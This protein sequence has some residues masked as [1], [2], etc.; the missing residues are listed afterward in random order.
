MESRGCQ[1]YVTIGRRVKPKLTESEDFAIDADSHLSIPEIQKESSQ[2]ASMSQS[3]ITPVCPYL[4]TG[5][6]CEVPNCSP[7]LAELSEMVQ[8]FK[9][10][11]R[12]LRVH[13]AR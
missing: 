11:S 1:A 4:K 2:Y 13:Q 9:R 3:R 7:P 12:L 8:Q 5:A 6:K 10:R